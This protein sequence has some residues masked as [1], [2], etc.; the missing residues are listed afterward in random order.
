M[1]YLIHAI[2]TFTVSIPTCILT[3]MVCDKFNIGHKWGER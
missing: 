1:K 2:I 3:N